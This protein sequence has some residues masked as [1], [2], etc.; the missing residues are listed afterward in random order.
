MKIKITTEHP[1]SSYG[2][3]VILIDDELQDYAPGIQ[4]IRR[5]LK[6]SCAELGEKLGVSGRTIEG[7]EQGRL[8]ETRALN[9]LADLLSKKRNC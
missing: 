9:A 2:Q 6:L 5:E 3:P 7:W 1:A 8:P 4:A